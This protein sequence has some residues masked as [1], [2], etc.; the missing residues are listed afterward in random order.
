MIAG[1]TLPGIAAKLGLHPVHGFPCLWMN[2]RIILFFYVDDIII[3]YHPDYL[4][5]FEK[6]EQQLVKL[7]GLCQMGNVKWFLGICVERLLASRQLYLIQDS[8]IVKVCT[9]FNLIC[10]DSKY[11]STPLATTSRLLSCQPTMS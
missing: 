9:E 6:L 4:E 10:T 7:Y 3:L 5:D 11:P 1:Y 2:D 8:F